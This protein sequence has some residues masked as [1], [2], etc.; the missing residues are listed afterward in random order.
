[1]KKHK[2]SIKIEFL[3][4]STDIQITLLTIITLLIK[5]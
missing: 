4:S 3:M 1:M 5:S 2:S